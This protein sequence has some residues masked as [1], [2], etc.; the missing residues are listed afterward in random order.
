MDRQ[1]V[2]ASRAN[3]VAVIFSETLVNPP[4]SATGVTRD[5]K[6]TSRLLP[7]EGGR[8][9]ATGPQPRSES[10]GGADR[11]PEGG[12]PRRRG[13]TR[14]SG[15]AGGRATPGRK[16]GVVAAESGKHPRQPDE[17]RTE[18]TPMV[19]LILISIP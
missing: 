17:G 7:A 16:P 9:R 8:F 13:Q 3:Q 5:G 1:A 6:D 18:F 12:P 4:S 11:S 19:Q 15:D 14:E 10:A 2:G